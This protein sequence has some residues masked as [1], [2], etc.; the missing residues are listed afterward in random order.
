MNGG[1]TPKAVLLSSQLPG[2][3]GLSPQP[4]RPTFRS[5][6]T[7]LLPPSRGFGSRQSHTLV[8]VPPRVKADVWALA[9]P[10][11]L[12]IGGLGP[13]NP[14]PSILWSPPPLPF[15][16]PPILAPPPSSFSLGGG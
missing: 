7:D 2:G 10:V 16:L 9:V 6:G 1:L 12:L 4:P 3:G 8:R 5:P 14:V 13:D 15:L 11:A